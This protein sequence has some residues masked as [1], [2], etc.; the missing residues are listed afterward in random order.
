MARQRW[1]LVIH[2]RADERVPVERKH[3]QFFE[4]IRELREPWGLGDRV[5]PEV[6]SF[7]RNVNASVNLTKFLGP[8]VFRAT[9]SYPYRARLTDTPSCDDVLTV[10][11]DPNRVEFL[12]LANDVVPAYIRALDAYLVECFDDREI[13]ERAVERPCN[14]RRDVCQVGLLNFW[15]DT[16]CR[17]AFGR[18]AQEVAERLQSADVDVRL[19][20]RGVYVLGGTD[21]SKGHDDTSRLSQEIRRLLG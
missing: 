13:D 21:P 16:L 15:D 9:L 4:A 12:Y 14:P 2:A 11:L 10:I 19:L 3:S 18:K 5:I 1:W 17:R 20:E 6:P 8:G 7:G